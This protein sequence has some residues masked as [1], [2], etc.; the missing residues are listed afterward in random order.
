MKDFEAASNNF[1]IY[2]KLP[3]KKTFKTKVKIKEIKKYKLKP[4]ID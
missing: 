4:F 1:D 3:V 2:V